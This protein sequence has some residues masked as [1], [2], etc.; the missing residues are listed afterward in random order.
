MV[1]EVI[2]G[3]GWLSFLIINLLHALEI[4]TKFGI[5]TVGDG[6]GVGTVLAVFLSVQKPVWDFVLTGVEHNSLHTT[7]FVLVQLSSSL[8]ITLDIIF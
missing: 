7:D 4:F 2:L 8:K 5:E 6:L 1:P 3:L